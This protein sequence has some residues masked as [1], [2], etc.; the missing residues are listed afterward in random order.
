MNM[1]AR[2]ICELIF[3]VAASFPGMAFA[4]LSPQH[5]VFVTIQR[6]LHCGYST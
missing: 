4:G 2:S 5:Q 3:D 1:W 6:A